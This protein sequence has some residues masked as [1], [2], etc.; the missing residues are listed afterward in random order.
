MG[1]LRRHVL[2]CH[3]LECAC[4]KCGVDRRSIPKTVPFEVHVTSCSAVRPKPSGG[5]AA[6][7][8]LCPFDDCGRRFVSDRDRGSHISSEHPHQEALSCPICADMFASTGAL[9]VHV[10]SCTRAA[11]VANYVCP[12]C[13]TGFTRRTNMLRHMVGIH[14]AKPN[15]FCDFCAASFAS[16]AALKRHIRGAHPDATFTCGKCEK[17]FLQ[18]TS[19]E[20]HQLSC[21]GAAIAC[22]LCSLPMNSIPEYNAHMEEFHKTFRRSCEACKKQFA[23]QRGLRQHQRHCAKRRAVAREIGGLSCPHCTL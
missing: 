1:H 17:V 20:A 18:M 2:R 3:D 9:C 16:P 8:F 4:P 6:A 21:S 11:L 23:S 14:Q 13:T 5:T 12:Y 22:A 19:R 15:S 7:R 10:D